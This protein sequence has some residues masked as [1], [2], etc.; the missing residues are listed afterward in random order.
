MEEDKMNKIKKMFFTVVV[1]MVVFALGNTGA[2]DNL[3]GLLNGIEMDSEYTE[4]TNKISIST[5]KITM[6]ETE[7][8][9]PI[10]VIFLKPEDVPFREVEWIEVDGFKILNS[11]GKEVVDA[12]EAN[13]SGSINDGVANL[14]FNIDKEKIVDGET[15]TVVIER[16]EGSR[17][18]D[19]SWELKGK[20][21]CTFE[22]K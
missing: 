5:G 2:V 18:A 6:S 16:I 20:W 4:V 3:K 11:K 22:M 14:V 1:L 12:K 17:K 9:M 8:F 21:S 7:I 13:V 10:E 19:A 15:Y